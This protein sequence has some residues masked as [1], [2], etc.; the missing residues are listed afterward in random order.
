MA[1]RAERTCPGSKSGAV[2][3]LR[4]TLYTNLD[5]SDRAVEVCLEYLR[6]IG[7]EWSPHP[8]E[9]EMRQEYEQLWLRLGS[10]SI[11]ELIDLPAMSDPEWRATLDVLTLLMPAANFTDENLFCLCVARMGREQTE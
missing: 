11:E 10:R 3:C 1:A 5:R 6:G 8:T 9:E 4:T 7:V 2:I